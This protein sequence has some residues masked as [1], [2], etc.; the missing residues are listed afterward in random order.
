MIRTAAFIAAVLI[1]DAPL[2]DTAS[3]E[4]YGALGTLIMIMGGLLIR[5]EVRVAKL[6]ARAEAQ[7]KDHAAELR[8]LNKITREALI[9]DSK[10]LEKFADALEA[11]T[12]AVRGRG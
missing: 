9:G 7:A 4:K 1:A 11:N 6:E 5:S 10:A 8:E 12:Q 3:L 2:S